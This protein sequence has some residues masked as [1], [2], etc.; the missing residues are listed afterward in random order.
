VKCLIGDGTSCANCER[1][2]FTCSFAESSP[3]GDGDSAQVSLPRRRV[4]LACINCHSRKAR[5]SGETPTCARCQSQG[6]D[7]VYRPTKRSGGVVAGQTGNS[8]HE[9]VSS[10]PPEKRRMTNEDA[11]ARNARFG[12]AENG[13]FVG[14]YSSWPPNHEPSVRLPLKTNCC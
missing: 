9:S 8:D 13:S 7:C 12:P 14:G 11:C 10:E 2:G 1:L 5:C 3:Q 4:R 6:I